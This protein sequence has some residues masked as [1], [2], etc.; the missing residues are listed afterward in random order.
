MNGRRLGA[1]ILVALVALA[2]LA[3][4]ALY[5][6]RPRMLPHNDAQALSPTT[7]TINRGEYLARA[8]DCVACH[9]SEQGA[10]SLSY[11]PHRACPPSALPQRNAVGRHE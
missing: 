8:G 3:A 4:G 9:T 7:Q 11:R 10:P 5:L 6:L 2:L 1:W